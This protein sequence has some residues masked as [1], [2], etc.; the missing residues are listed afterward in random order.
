MRL[1]HSLNRC[2]ESLIPTVKI[3]RVTH[4]YMIFNCLSVSFKLGIID[5]L[6]DQGPLNVVE[7]ARITK[8]HEKNLF[9]V[10]R[11]LASEGF[12][13]FNDKNQKFSINKTSSLLT[14]GGIKSEKNL[15]S[16][17]SMLQY[18]AFM[19][20][21]QSLYECVQTGKTG[22][23]IENNMTFF[24]YIDEKDSDYKKIFDA[25]MKQKNEMTGIHTQ[26]AKSFN[27]SNYET[28]CDVGGGIGH[29]GFEILSQHPSSKI[30]VMEIEQCVKNALDTYKRDSTKLKAI[31]Q[32]KIKFLVGDMFQPK[33]I[34]SSNIYTLMQVIHDWN[35]QDAIRILSSIS[36]VMRKD[37][38]K[39]I[40]NNQVINDNNRPKLL[41]IDQI[42]NDNNFEK[43]SFKKMVIS[44]LIMMTV[45]GGEERTL[46]QW[47]SLFE[48][49]GLTLLSIKKL[50]RPPFLSI[51]ELTV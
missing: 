11:V 12:I 26:V 22:F 23:E 15:E 43:E 10:L 35:N 39:L 37:K 41:I 24:Q 38:S 20:S 45:V 16:L 34:P 29:L 32:D 2:W 46:L 6:A 36:S 50:N 13:S 18:P 30:C 28:I 44:D 5:H 9:R 14:S 19:N 40:N 1:V 47:K 27:F 4:D 33:T 49:S 7:L 25:A 48:Q 21:W 51:L 3:F 31:Q 42:L 8:S 17:F